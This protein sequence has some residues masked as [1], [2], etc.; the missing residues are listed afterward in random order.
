MFGIVCTRSLAA[1]CGIVLAR[2]PALGF[3]ITFANLAN[4]L[5]FGVPL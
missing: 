5:N 2:F 3:L 1:V 4:L